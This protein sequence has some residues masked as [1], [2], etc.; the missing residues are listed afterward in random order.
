[1]KNKKV[2]YFLGL[3][4]V[5]VWGMI[6]YR[7][8]QAVSAED[9]HD[10]QPRLVEKKEEYNDYEV[11]KDTTKLLLN[12]RDPFSEGKQKDTVEIPINK[13]VHST[14]PHPIT[15]KPALN[16]GFIRYSGFV[17][18]PG[19]KRIIA[20]V[21]INGKQQMLSEGETAD[22]VKLIKNMKDSIKVLYQGNTKFITMNT[23]G[24]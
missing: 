24:Q 23:K 22:Q 8:F 9:N 13:L 11:P 12:Y 20:I 4:V 5:A 3:L 7:V 14:A 10:F 2:T 17:Y 1:M 18:N 6:I 15:Q 21:S 16:W 19:S